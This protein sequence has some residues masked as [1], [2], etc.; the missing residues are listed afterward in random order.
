MPKAEPADPLVERL[1][2]YRALRDELDHQQLNDDDVNP[3]WGFVPAKELEMPIAKE[4]SAPR[5]PIPEGMYH[6]ICYAV[7]DLGTQPPMPNS[8]YK[9]TDRKV[10]FC[11]EFP[12]ER[13][14]DGQYPRAA[15][16]E[17]TLSLH[18]KAGLRKFLVAWR[19]KQFTA[20]ELKG[21]DL[22]NVLGVNAMINIVHNDRGYET[23]A[24][25]TP[26]MKGM[27]KRQPE[28]DVTLYDIEDAVIPATVPEW[29]RKKIAVSEEMRGAQANDRGDE[30]EPAPPPS[31]RARYADDDDIPF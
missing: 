11:F 24:S 7:I 16:K 1:R 14:T 13:S 30:R 26:L 17:F 10:M 25:C 5:D 4:T 15:T 12:E 19:G 6:A 29:V 28:N 23:I 31:D 2:A 3:A 18:E 20:D 9:K 21:F 22:K 27:P 8:L